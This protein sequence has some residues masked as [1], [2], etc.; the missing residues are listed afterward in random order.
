MSVKEPKWEVSAELTSHNPPDVNTPERMLLW[1]IL[2]RALL[3]LNNPERVI[4]KKAI[5]WFISNDSRLPRGFG[6]RDV[7]DIL[8]LDTHLVTV[9]T[10]KV[11]DVD[12]KEKERISRGDAWRAV[13]WR[14]VRI[15]H[16]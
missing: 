14:Q 15:T 8:E 11:Y 5:R 3:D 4:R 12:A 16:F 13:P 7:Q 2:E 9:I 10:N 1:G 6:W